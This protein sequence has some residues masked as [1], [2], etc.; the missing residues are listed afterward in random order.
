MRKKFSKDVE[1]TCNKLLTNFFAMNQKCDNMAYALDTYLNCS[2]AAKVYHLKFAHQFP[3][4]T[5]ADKFSEVLAHEGITPYRYAQ[6]DDMVKYDDIAQL[7]TK[8][9]ENVWELKQ[10]ILEAIEILDYDRENKV[11]VVALEDMVANISVLVHQGE[12]WAQKAKTYVADGKVYKF[13]IDFE[14]FTEI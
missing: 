10:N 3:S 6:Q 8:N 11:I 5:Y 4:D 7:F 12:V 2:Q 14:E 13:D 1:M 9:F